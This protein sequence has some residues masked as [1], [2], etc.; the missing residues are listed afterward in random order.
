MNSSELRTLYDETMRRNASV[1]GCACEQ[2]AHVCRY[3]T[4]TGSLRYIMWHDLNDELAAAV[5][6]RTSIADSPDFALP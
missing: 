2:S 3:T 1:A 5:N 6:S 4:A